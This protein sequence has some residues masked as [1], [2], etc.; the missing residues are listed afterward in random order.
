MINGFW[1]AKIGLHAAVLVNGAI[2]CAAAL[3]FFLFANQTPLRLI[4]SQ[5]RPWIAF[6]GLC[7]FSIVAIAAFTFPR[8]GAASVVVL[9]VSGQ[10]LMSL[11]ADHLGVLNL[12]QHAIS[13]MRLLGAVLVILGVIFTTKT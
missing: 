4:G 5:I 6:N 13:P 2:V 12:P 8:I 10:I 1:Q 9:M 11:V 3:F 7:G